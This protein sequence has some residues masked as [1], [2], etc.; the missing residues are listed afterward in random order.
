[1]HSFGSFGSGW[2]IYKKPNVR[3]FQF[4]FTLKKNESSFVEVVVILWF[5]HIY[6]LFLKYEHWVSPLFRLRPLNTLSY[7]HIFNHSPFHTKRRVKERCAFRW[8]QFLEQ[9]NKTYTQRK[10]QDM[11]LQKPTIKL[12]KRSI[13]NCA[14]VFVWGLKQLNLEARQK[15]NMHVNSST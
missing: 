13:C 3:I 4:I 14:N 8:I 2:T 15:T 11:W 1:M 12:K 6:C 9:M 7:Q 10:A 5:K